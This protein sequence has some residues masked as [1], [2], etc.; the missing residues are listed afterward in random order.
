M[1]SCNQVVG[2]IVSRAA[3]EGGL[4][5]LHQKL[6][7]LNPRSRKRPRLRSIDRPISLWLFHLFPSVLNAIVVVK[8]EAVLR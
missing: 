7:V 4:V 5:V 8:P 3:R 6:P 2:E 1:S